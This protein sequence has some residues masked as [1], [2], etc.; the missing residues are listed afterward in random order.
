MKFILDNLALFAIALSSGALLIWPLLRK[1]SGAAALTPLEATQLIN[2]RNAVVVDVRDEK[3][4]ALGSLA[5]A[6]HLPFA[7]L[8][9]RAAELVRFKSRPLLIVCATGQTAAKAIASFKAQ[10]FD[11]VYALAGGIAGWSQA[12]IPL[13]QPGREAA[14]AK[15]AARKPRN[16]QRGGRSKRDQRALSPPPL[17]AAGAAAPLDAALLASDPI[18]DP[19][20]NPARDAA[21]DVRPVK[22]PS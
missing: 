20:G 11:E 17:Q 4:Y 15:E 7:D 10:G 21:V 14:R 12:G 8:A 16:D 5:G 19:I 9:T 13:V 1:G 3:D 6:R 18:S 22:E 2:H